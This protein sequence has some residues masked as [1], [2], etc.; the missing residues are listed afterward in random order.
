MIISW[1]FEA[2]FNTPRVVVFIFPGSAM[3]PY[4]YAHIFEHGIILK[5]YSFLVLHGNS[6]MVAVGHMNL[7]K[8]L[9]LA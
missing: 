6:C 9:L 8:F 3:C 7:L 5:E 2:A 1:A 4:S